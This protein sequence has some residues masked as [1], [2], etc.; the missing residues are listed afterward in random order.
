MAHRKTRQNEKTGKSYEAEARWAVKCL[1]EME[2]TANLL[3]EDMSVD[4]HFLLK[5]A[6]PIGRVISKIDEKSVNLMNP[7][8]RGDFFRSYN[9]AV[10]T[11]M[12]RETNLLEPLIDSGLVGFG[13]GKHLDKYT[14]GIPALE[15]IADKLPS[16]S[17]IY[18]GYFQICLKIRFSEIGMIPS[19][20][21]DADRSPP[22]A[23]LPEMGIAPEEIHPEQFNAHEFV[24]IVHA[25]TLLFLRR[26][27]PEIG[28]EMA[29]DFAQHTSTLILLWLGATGLL[30]AIANSLMIGRPMLRCL[31]GP[32]GEIKFVMGDEGSRAP[33]FRVAKV[34][35]Q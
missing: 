16:F 30:Q 20:H 7:A 33:L 12:A 24:L 4:I 3:Q 17:I 31:P 22:D 32:D 11:E 9:A 8:R 14:D 15:P 19:R 25:A 28:K 35:D 5:K 27:H 1:D 21:L 6:D 29:T 13:P 34:Q 2:S 26:I 23:P 18:L 10:V